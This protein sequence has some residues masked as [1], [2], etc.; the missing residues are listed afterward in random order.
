METV[1]RKAVPDD[2]P[3]MARL[4]AEAWQKAYRGILSDALLDNIDDAQR[5]A[6]M[7]KSIETNSAF[8]YY[9]LEADGGIAGVSGMCAL[10]DE[11]LPAAGEIKVFYICT[12]RQGQGLGK[13]MMR[14]S[15]DVLR[16]K[17]F[18]RVA[19]WVLKDNHPSRAFYEAVGFRPDG[20]EKAMPFLEDAHAVRYRYG[21]AL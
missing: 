13:T 16:E 4:V 20:A 2:A 7:Q 11:D 17:G 3:Q 15:L 1:F 10:A 21:D 18:P 5:I 6:S 9:V 19:L 14:H 8:W 12:D